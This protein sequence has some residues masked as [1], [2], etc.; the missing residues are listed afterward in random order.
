MYRCATKAALTALFAAAAS[1]HSA[2]VDQGDGFAFFES[3]IR[4]LL[5]ERCFEC[6]SSSSKKIKGGLT[7]D[8]HERVLKGGDSGPAIVP[9]SPEK[10]LLIKA[11]RYGDKDL[12]MPPKHQLPLTE[13]ALL[14]DWVKM[15]AP[16]P[17]TNSMPMTSPRNASAHWAFQPVSDPCVPTVKNAR[18][19]RTS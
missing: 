8:S 5:A 13:I 19:P 7:L 2:A 14:E 1:V 18:W 16:D 3:K 6:H 9:G 12:Q 10:S 11:V 15:G 4:P 17:R